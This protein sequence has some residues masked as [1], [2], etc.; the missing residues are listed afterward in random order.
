[1][2]VRVICLS[3]KI[4]QMVKVKEDGIN[5]FAYKIVYQ[6]QVEENLNKQNVR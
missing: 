3:R 5:T 2:C 1:M 4:K 6:T